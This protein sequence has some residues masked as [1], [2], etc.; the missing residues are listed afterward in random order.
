MIL[1]YEDIQRLTVG[2]LEIWQ[3]EDGFHFSCMTRGQ[4]ATFRSLSETLCR[5]AAATTGVHLAFLTDSCFLAFTPGTDGKYEVKVDGELLPREAS[6]AGISY[7]ISLP[8]DGKLHR[9]A[10]HLPSHALGVLREVALSDGARVLPLP[11]RRRFLFLGDS[12]TQGW[13]SKFD[14]LSYAYQVSEHF[15][16]ESVIQ[17]TGGAYYAEETLEPL[18]FLPE[19]IFVAYGTNDASRTRDFPLIVEN[20]K[21]YWQKLRSLFPTA[22]ITVITPP[23]RMDTVCP[24]PY[25][26]MQELGELL[27]KAAEEMGLSCVLGYR[28]FPGTE[29]FMADALHPNDLGF[30]L[31]AHNL[32][33]SLALGD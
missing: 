20:A 22:H 32:I 26:G 16:A 23:P 8:R 31:Y 27:A 19:E 17:G 29:D 21:K 18:P 33:R 14:T 9:V 5:N 13:N 11:R 3:E 15:D 4:L 30:S 7:S 2:A 1:S 10:L 12:I 25:G 6:R 28:L 24:G